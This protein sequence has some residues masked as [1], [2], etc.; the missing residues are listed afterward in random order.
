MQHP[1]AGSMGWLFLEIQKNSIKLDI[2]KQLLGKSVKTMNQFPV[3]KCESVN[4]GPFS[5]STGKFISLK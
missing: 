4:Y 2:K 3:D 1:C 5:R